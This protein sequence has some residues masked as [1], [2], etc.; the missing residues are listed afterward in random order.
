M[1][2]ILL[3]TDFSDNARNAARFA[4]NAFGFE[5]V[6]YVLLNAY[7]MPHHSSGM[8]INLDD[9]LKKDAEEAMS[10]EVAFLKSAYPGMGDN[11]KTL[12]RKGEITMVVGKAVAAEKADMIFMGTKGSADVANVLMGSSTRAV[13]KASVVP[14]LVVPDG[15]QF[16]GIKRV[17]FANDGK[18]VRK[19]DNLKFLEKLM[20][21][22]GSGILF[23]HVSDQE[24]T[25]GKTP[26][27]ESQM[28]KAFGNIPMS[29]H[30]ISDDSVGEGI[31]AFCEKEGINLLVM[32]TRGEGFLHRLFH[33]SETRRMVMH[34][35]FPLL[36]LQD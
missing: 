35:H 29:W 25:S 15:A 21:R 34:T 4:M 3:P 22:F 6:R 26:E 30:T 18:A 12:C 19:E 9:V 11:L 14:V 17:A 28:S 13:L 5:E 31:S 8:M 32:L 1:L 16:S 10:K 20:R 27:V 23:F 36:V 24:D 2:T 7:D 33:G